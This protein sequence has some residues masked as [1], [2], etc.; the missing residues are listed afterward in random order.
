[1]SDFPLDINRLT[2]MLDAVHSNKKIH[3][4]D[5]FDINEDKNNDEFI[6]LKELLEVEKTTLQMMKKLSL[7]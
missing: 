6:T 5:G 4:I 7:D 1:M 3:L 2:M